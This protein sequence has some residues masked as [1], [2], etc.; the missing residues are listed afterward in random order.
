M[1]K[2]IVLIALMFSFSVFALDINEA[3]EQGLI[4]E[5]AN[6]LLGA[7]ESIPEVEALV[8]RINEQ[9][10]DKYSQVANKNEMTV[11]QISLLAGEKLI[12]KAPAGQYIKNATGQWVIK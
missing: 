9:R 5:Q 2:I 12:K 3:K 10:L 4:G 8:K 1:K 7:V 11:E 6:G